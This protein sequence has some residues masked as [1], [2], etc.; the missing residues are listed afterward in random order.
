MLNYPWAMFLLGF[1]TCLAIVL[2]IA[3]FTEPK[4]NEKKGR[5]N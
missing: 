1:A 4:E 3:I 2:L 5:K